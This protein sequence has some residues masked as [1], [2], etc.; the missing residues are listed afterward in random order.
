MTLAKF[1]ADI[2]NSCI[3]HIPHS[4]IKI[5]GE[6]LSYFD[7]N[8]LEQELKLSTDWATDDIFRIEELKTIRFDYSRLFVDV[9]RLEENEPMEKYGRGISYTRA[10]GG[11]ELHKP[12]DS[13][14]ISK[15]KRHYT[16]HHDTLTMLTESI[17]QRE[18]NTQFCTIFDCHSFNDEPLPFEIDNL[19]EQGIEIRPRPD[20]CIGTDNFHT[21]KWLEDRFVDY[22]VTA[23]YSVRVNDP[24]GGAIVPLKYYQKRKNVFAIMIEINKRL[25]MG[26]NFKVKHQM[27]EK[28]NKQ[29]HE[30]LEILAGNT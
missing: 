28:L 12:Y 29:W 6:V 26:K 20:I 2:Y 13:S 23:G 7:E 3:M 22:F 27:V 19:R 9:E 8:L 10:S 11:K 17:C 21:P 30:L 5:P 24:Y 18:N 14:V 25:Y 16:T 1:S 15:I 4:A